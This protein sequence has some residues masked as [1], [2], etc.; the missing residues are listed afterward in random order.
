M[1]RP[2]RLDSEALTDRPIGSPPPIAASTTLSDGNAP[3]R[4]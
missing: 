1:Y 2:P 4:R 3:D